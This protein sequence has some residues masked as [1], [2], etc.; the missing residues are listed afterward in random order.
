[1]R[2][3]RYACG[4][5]L[6]SWMLRMRRMCTREGL[7]ELAKRWARFLLNPRLLLCLAIAWMITN[8]WSYVMFGLGMLMKIHW[9]RVVGGAYMSFLWLPFTPEK[10]M[11][12]VLAIGLMRLLYPRDRRTLGV[13]RRKLKQI[14]RRPEC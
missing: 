9:M 13:L 11:T 10:L 6:R 4:A 3:G 5:R 2:N 1:M 14:S 7:R 12:V 8:G